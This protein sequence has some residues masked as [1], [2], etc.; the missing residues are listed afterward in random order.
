MWSSRG[1]EID[2]APV[3]TRPDGIDFN[4]STVGLTKNRSMG[5]LVGQETTGQDENL[6]HNGPIRCRS[7]VI[8]STM[9]RNGAGRFNGSGWDGLLRGEHHPFVWQHHRRHERKRRRSKDERP[10][11]SGI[12][13]VRPESRK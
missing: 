3:T 12:P 5:M 7:D 2:L 10:F 6:T 11:H 1:T 13:N 8:N 4:I 9:E